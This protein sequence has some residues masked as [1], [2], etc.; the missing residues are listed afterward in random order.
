MAETVSLSSLKQQNQLNNSS[1]MSST[2]DRCCDESYTLS[3][4]VSESESSSSFSGGNRFGAVSSSF[5]SSPHGGA[6]RTLSVTDIN[7]PSAQFTFPL[8]GGKDDD[9]GDDDVMVWEK[10]NPKN[11]PDTDLSG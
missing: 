7:F 8:F 10:K 11:Q 6:F 9:V 4:D 5:T 2:S 1:S 3:A